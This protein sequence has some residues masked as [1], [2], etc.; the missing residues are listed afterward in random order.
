M[1]AVVNKVYCPAKIDRWILVNQSESICTRAGILLNRWPPRCVSQCISFSKP[2]FRS[3]GVLTYISNIEMERSSFLKLNSRY[4]VK[5][6]AGSDENLSRRTSFKI[7]C[8]PIV[9]NVFNAQ[10]KFQ[11]KSLDSKEFLPAL[12][13]RWLFL[14]YLSFISSSNNTVSKIAH[15]IEKSGYEGGP[16]FVIPLYESVNVW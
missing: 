5:R 4:R 14:V 2:R 6:R 12:L 11:W 9:V 8:E 7:R 15:V 16:F 10:Q 3:T 1:A 13:N